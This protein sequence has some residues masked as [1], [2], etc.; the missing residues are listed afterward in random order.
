L[1]KFYTQFT[2]K[3]K[4]SENKAWL[5]Q[6]LFVRSSNNEREHEQRFEIF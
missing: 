2:K 6:I 3:L 1:N 5:Y 4:K